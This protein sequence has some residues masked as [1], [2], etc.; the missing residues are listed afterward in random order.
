M[1][2]APFISIFDDATVTTRLEDAELVVLLGGDASRRA[3]EIAPMPTLPA[4]GS[5][6]RLAFLY[7]GVPP[8]PPSVV[9]THGSPVA[10]P[11]SAT[12]PMPASPSGSLAPPHEADQAPGSAD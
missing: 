11:F 10:P 8:A 2:I 3:G 5:A 1:S 4:R 9:R 6:P 7:P 12:A